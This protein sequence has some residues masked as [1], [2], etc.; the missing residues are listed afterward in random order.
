METKD[1]AISYIY[2][3]YLRAEEH[4]DR[5]QPDSCKRNPLLTKAIIQKLCRKPA[6]VVTGSKGKGSVAY[7]IS[8]LLQ[9]QKKVGLMTSPHL[10]EFNERF[11]VN[12]DVIT[13]RDLVRIVSEL[14]PQFDLVQ[15]SLSDREYISP[16]GIQAAIALRFFEECAT[17][18]NVFECGKGAKYDDV[19]Q[20]VHEYAVIAPV[21]LEHTRELGRTVREIAEDKAAV[22]TE[23]TR[24]VYVGR[25][26]QE[27]L[28]AI[29][30]RA[31]KLGVETRV[32]GR[33]FDCSNIRYGRE[34][35]QTDIIIGHKIYRDVEI[36]LLG[37]HQACNLAMAMAV[38]EDILGG[39]DMGPCRQKLR[40][41]QWPGRLE[42]VS[43]NPLVVL[44]A[45]IN[46]ESCKSVK[47]VLRQLDAKGWTAVIGIPDDKDYLGV[48]EE[49][50]EI[51]DEIIL[52][53][54]DNPHYQFSQIQ[55][56]NA[57]EKGWFVSRTSCVAEALA[58]A[59]K[60]GGAVCILGTT[61]LVAEVSAQKRELFPG[62]A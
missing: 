61:A 53:R 6:I 4:L 57:L 60:K 12:G 19:N 28:Q 50:A 9:M 62:R 26:P 32:L 13:D 44:D 43:A 3:S 45:C 27:A 42:V 47:D 33:D 8:L 39:L 5:D 46:R 56:R 22:I 7:M 41:M 20:I 15:E 48:I 24:R 2:Q 31:H 10:V 52:T 38:C 51:A 16:M 35:T 21:F 1:S 14:K 36:P 29:L 54:A 25:Q 59:E 40:Q 23:D 17:E 37:V 18:I 30:G 34:G 11:R 49:I 58:L 55:E